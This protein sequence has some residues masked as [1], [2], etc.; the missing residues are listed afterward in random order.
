MLTDES[1]DSGDGERARF[2][3]TGLEAGAAF[4]AGLV[5]RERQEGAAMGEAGLED[6]LLALG[7]LIGET[8]RELAARLGGEGERE[9][10]EGRAGDREVLDFGGD[11]ER[12]RVGLEDDGLGV[13]DRLRPEEADGLGLR[14]RVGPRALWI[15]CFHEECFLDLT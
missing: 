5:E 15:R 1:L 10:A 12:L 8:D 9:D 7:F 13:R 3:E 11:R 2:L 4:V 14:E 6:L